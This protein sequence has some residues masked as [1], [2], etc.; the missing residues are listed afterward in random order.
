VPGL[1]AKFLNELP[2]TF[3]FGGNSKSEILLQGRIAE[4]IVVCLFGNAPGHHRSM[5]GF[6]H[7]APNRRAVRIF[8]QY[9]PSHPDSRCFI[10]SILKT[11]SCGTTQRRAPHYFFAAVSGEFLMTR[12]SNKNCTIPV[13]IHIG[14]RGGL[15]SFCHATDPI[16]VPAE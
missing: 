7:R 12:R 6:S 15:T 10:P 3:L 4:L 9:S 11:I 1:H 5:L 2:Q 14:H 13:D 16:T 8:E